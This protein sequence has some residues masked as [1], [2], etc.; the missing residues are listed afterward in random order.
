MQNAFV[1]PFDLEWDR[2]WMRSKVR[3]RFF[4]DLS[5]QR[6]RTGNWSN[7]FEEVNHVYFLRGRKAGWW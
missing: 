2:A 4:R 5:V 6:Q 1:W 3:R 7:M